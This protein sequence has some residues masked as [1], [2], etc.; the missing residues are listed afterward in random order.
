VQLSGD[1]YISP[2]QDLSP[3]ILMLS[4]DNS[5]WLDLPLRLQRQGYTV[6]AMPLRPDTTANSASAL[7]DFE[8]MIMAL[9][10]VADPGHLAVVGAET[11]ADMALAGCAVEL[12]CDALVLLTPTDLDIAQNTI[13]RYNPR[14]I[15]LS[16]ARNDGV[17]FGIVEYLRGSARGEIG[18]DLVDG[19]ARGAALLQTDPPLTDRL[20]EW[21]GT[22]LL[23]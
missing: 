12:L 17:N 19:Q 21:L 22:Q 9:A 2:T 15:Y 16:V 4:A 10:Q 13:I 18:Y 1:L 11:G 3:G 7:G 23:G 5:A 14:P 8:A 20:I 6:L